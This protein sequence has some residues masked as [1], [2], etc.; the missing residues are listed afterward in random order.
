MNNRSIILHKLFNF[1]RLRQQYETENIIIKLAETLRGR[2]TK[3]FWTWTETIDYRPLYSGS[4]LPFCKEST[5]DYSWVMYI[6]SFRQRDG[7]R[8]EVAFGSCSRCVIRA[9]SINSD[10]STFK[11]KTVSIVAAYDRKWFSGAVP[12]V[13]NGYNRL[14]HTA[15]DSRHPRRKTLVCRNSIRSQRLL[16]GETL[17][18]MNLV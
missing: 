2:T 9:F 8:I 13:S 14:G 17:C 5:A 3:Y 10:C 16:G 1:I 7:S 11:L 15:L 12:E 18:K 4:W 6:Q